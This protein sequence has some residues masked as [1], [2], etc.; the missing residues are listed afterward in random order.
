MRR[1]LR[2]SP[3]ARKGDDIELVPGRSCAKAALVASQMVRPARSAAI[4]SPFGTRTPAGRA[5]PGEDDIA[6]R[7]RWSRD[8][9]SRRRAVMILRTSSSFSCLTT[10]VTQPAE[11]FPGQHVVPVVRRASTTWPS[12]RRRCPTPGRC[13]C[14]SPRARRGCR[15]S[16]RSRPSA[17]PCRQRRGATGRE[18]RQGALRASNRDASRR[19]Q[20]KNG[21]WPDARPAWVL[22]S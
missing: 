10:S 3:S 14:G 5:V 17:W 2:P 7:N 11:A 20:K 22:S 12:R 16:G 8:P 15:A 1:P 4:A 18:P 13:R 6:C 21:D 9:A 19:D